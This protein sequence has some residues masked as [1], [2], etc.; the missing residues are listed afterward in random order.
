MRRGSSNY[1]ERQIAFT[2]ILSDKASENPD[3]YNWNRMKVRYCDGA[4]FSG[5]GENKA[6]GLQFRGQRIYHAAMDELMSTGKHNPNQDFWP[7]A[8]LGAGRNQAGTC[9]NHGDPTSVQDL[10]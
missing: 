2:G 7:D 9:S 1:F 5:E 6:A 10:G 3:F 8:L 4:S